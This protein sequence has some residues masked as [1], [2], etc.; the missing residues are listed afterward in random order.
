M[1][2]SFY[3]LSNQMKI[4]ICIIIYRIHTLYVNVMVVIKCSYSIEYNTGMYMHVI[5]NLLVKYKLI[6]Q[7]DIV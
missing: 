4:Q 3:D 2:R 1:R 6:T 7:S 5:T